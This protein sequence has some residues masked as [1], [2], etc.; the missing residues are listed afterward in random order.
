MTNDFIALEL[1]KAWCMQPS[2]AASCFRMDD[3]LDNYEKALKKLEEI[4]KGGLEDGYDTSRELACEEESEES[5]EE[6]SKRDMD[7]TVEDYEKKFR[8]LKYNFQGVDWEEVKEDLRKG[9]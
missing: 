6:N 9:V 1:V 7:D 3:V 8:S 5:L 4:R 2:T